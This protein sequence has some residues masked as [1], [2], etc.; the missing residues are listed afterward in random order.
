[1]YQRKTETQDPSSSEM[2]AKDSH[3]S[4]LPPRLI[5][6]GKASRRCPTNRSCP[7]EP[8]NSQELACF[9]YCLQPVCSPTREPS[10]L[11]LWKGL[12]SSWPYAEKPLSCLHQEKQR[13]ASP[14]IS[15]QKIK[16]PWLPLQ[17]SSDFTQNIP[18]L[19][20]III[21]KPSKVQGSE[22]FPKLITKWFHQITKVSG[23][24]QNSSHREAP[25]FFLTEV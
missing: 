22:H 23:Y 20:N 5:W 12:K 10:L 9:L 18:L 7:K 19:K 4:L 2:W 21:G 16:R 24:K 25:A 1:M 15:L 11:S 13:K 14:Y 17:S 6:G 8:L 3:Y